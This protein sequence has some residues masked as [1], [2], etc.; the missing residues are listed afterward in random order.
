MRD[1]ITAS[2]VTC[3]IAQGSYQTAWTLACDFMEYSGLLVTGEDERHWEGLILKYRVLLQNYFLNGPS[4][5]DYELQRRCIQSMWDIAVMD[6]R[7]DLMIALQY[8]ALYWCTRREMLQ[9]FKVVFRDARATQDAVF[10]IL[11]P[12]YSRLGLRA[13]VPTQLLS[14]LDKRGAAGHEALVPFKVP[15]RKTPR[16]LQHDDTS[17]SEYSNLAHLEGSMHGFIMMENYTECVP[18]EVASGESEA[19]EDPASDTE[20]M[21]LAEWRLGPGRKK[22][23][24]VHPKDKIPSR[25]Q[26]RRGQV[27]HGAKNVKQNLGTMGTSQ[28]GQRRGYKKNRHDRYVQKFHRGNTK[29]RI[30]HLWDDDFEEYGTSSYVNFEPRVSVRAAEILDA[31]AVLT[32]D[33]QPIAVTHNSFSTFYGNKSRAAKRGRREEAIYERIMADLPPRLPNGPTEKGTSKGKKHKQRG[34]DKFKIPHCN[35]LK[36]LRLSLERFWKALLEKSA[37][38]RR[39]A[40]GQELATAESYL[41]LYKTV[42]ARRHQLTQL[43]SIY[44]KMNKK[45][46]QVQKG[47]RG[48]KKEMTQLKSW[49]VSAMEQRDMRPRSA[50]H[51]DKFIYSL[52]QPK[53]GSSPHYPSLRKHGILEKES[54]LIVRLLDHWSDVGYVMVY[55]KEVGIKIDTWHLGQL[56]VLRHDLHIYM[57]EGKLSGC[58]ETP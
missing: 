23:W 7:N 36:D 50:L 4:I 22:S 8:C 12:N 33:D 35:D 55:M 47:V 6:I 9:A 44:S 27:L 58:I 45:Y 40:T 48:M 2:A 15:T 57:K 32:S 52:P 37:L 54:E 5:L 39:L 34:I 46:K 49:L 31:D 28:H 29:Q 21:T 53:V 38:L 18:A 43:E 26:H 19:R 51:K 16:R 10:E 17:L 14:L 11:A 20:E 25:L 42:E 41:K 24:K 1:A 56:S 3:S 13:F 30:H